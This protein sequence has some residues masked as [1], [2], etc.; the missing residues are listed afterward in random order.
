MLSNAIQRIFKYSYRV[1]YICILFYGFWI[2]VL[3]SK[4]PSPQHCPYTEHLPPKFSRLLLFYFLHLSLIYMEF[5]FVCGI[6]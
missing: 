6:K 3:V 5:I 4:A 2:P 1:K